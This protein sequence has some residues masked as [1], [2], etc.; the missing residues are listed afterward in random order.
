MVQRSTNGNVYDCRTLKSG[1]E[2]TLQGNTEL[3]NMGFDV[4]CFNGM[5]HRWNKWCKTLEEAQKEFD[6]WD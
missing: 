4:D 5:E 3:A 1:E 6:R 2:I